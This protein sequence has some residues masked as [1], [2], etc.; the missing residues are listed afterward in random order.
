M[1]ASE[2]N[3]YNFKIMLFCHFLDSKEMSSKSKDLKSSRMAYQNEVLAKA[4]L[5]RMPGNL[6]LPFC[7][8]S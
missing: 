6:A 1:V 4:I 2:I 5:Q 8:L 3:L 7:S